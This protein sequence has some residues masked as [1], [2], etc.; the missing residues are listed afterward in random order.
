MAKGRLHPKDERNVKLGFVQRL[1]KLT[2][3]WQRMAEP[4]LQHSEKMWKAYASGYLTKGYARNHTINL[5]DR[6]VSTVVPFLVDG[7]PRVHVDTL[8][9]MYRPWAATTELALNFYIKNLHLSE[10]V[11]IPSARNSMFSAA[12][13]RTNL[14][15]EKRIIYG[16]QTLR[17]SKPEVYTIDYA[18]YVGDPAAKKREDM[19]FEGHI[20]RLET[21]YAR[22]FFGK[23][24]DLITPD[25]ELIEDHSPEKIGKPDFNRNTLALRDFSTFIDLYLYDENTV[26]TIMPDG[27][28]PRIIRTM[29]WQ[30]PEGGPYDVLGY[31]FIDE[32]PIPIPPAWSWH[33]MDV[34][35]N[36]LIDKMREQAEAQK[37]ILVYEG[38]AEDDA[39]RVV[40]SGNNMSVRVENIQAIQHL[41]FGGVNPENY[42][43]VDYV[44]NQ[45]TKQGSNP[46]VMAGRGA[47]AP[48]LGQEQMVYA[49]ATRVVGTMNSRFHAFTE[50]ILRKLA[51]AF[52]NNPTTYV[53][54]IKEV[55]GLGELPVVFDS[56]DKV[57]DFYEFAFNITPYSMQREV[58]ETKYQKLMQFLTQWIMPTMQFA[59][60]QGNQLDIAEAT[61]ILASY[62][63]VTNLEH[64]Y[65]TAVP[66]MDK[67]SLVDYQM[68]PSGQG[69]DAF[70]ATLGSRT[71]N[72]DQQQARAGGQPSPRN[73]PN[74]ATGV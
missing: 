14:V 3:A 72:S 58:P 33:D 30:G 62:L 46:D 9:P 36:L 49:N 16:D 44:E 47:Q 29:E 21:D 18:N 42:Q 19:V 65:K 69:N 32:H 22:E 52:W 10:R 57:G 20:Y 4:A 59:S 54:V 43:W 27:K 39:Q 41:Q 17:L 11:L 31:K 55:P 61:K 64:F 51:W 70:G 2:T 45:F 38:Q 34:T 23:G 67:T 8:I 48:T 50:S 74:A 26:V 40:T 73:R 28:K 56:T 15:D 25:S 60:A 71:A 12:V 53:P 1:Q 66:S 7:E 6:G 35:M 13:T 63:G 24:E 5:L 68:Q 37:N